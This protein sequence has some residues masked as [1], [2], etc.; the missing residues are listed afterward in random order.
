ML[1]GQ[2]CQRR[3]HA[4]IAGALELLRKILKL[5]GRLPLCLRWACVVV[6]VE[7]GCKLLILSLVS[8][9]RDIVQE[10]LANLPRLP[11][12][13]FNLCFGNTIHIPVRA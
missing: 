11:V 9:T 4:I 8:N 10:I 13:I 5:T 7:G 1:P 12:A 6:V 2:A 3:R